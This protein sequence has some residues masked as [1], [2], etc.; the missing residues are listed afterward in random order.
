ML[1][2]KLQ[3]APRVIPLCAAHSPP[4]GRALHSG[5]RTLTSRSSAHDFITYTY[6]LVACAQRALHATWLSVLGLSP[7]TLSSGAW[8]LNSGVGALHLGLGAL[9][10]G[11]SAPPGVRCTQSG[12]QRSTL[13]CLSP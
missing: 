9:K 3:L 6:H 12:P 11:P 13:G 8:V 1:V 4:C 10:A 5:S 2:D 7:I